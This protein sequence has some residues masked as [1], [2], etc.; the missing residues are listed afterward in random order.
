MA[1]LV[2][3]NRVWEINSAEDYH[4]AMKTLEESEFCAEMSDSYY[5][6]RREKAEIAR[7]RADIRR[8]V[9]EKGIVV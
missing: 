7:Q 5:V 8:Q 4:K 3:F 9:Q 6:T 2:R 1:E